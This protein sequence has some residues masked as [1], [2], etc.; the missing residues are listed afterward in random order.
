[1]SVRS[2]KTGASALSPLGESDEG[3][4][5]Y[6]V[7]SERAPGTVL[8]PIRQVLSKP[9][10]SES[11][12]STGSHQ[13]GRTGGTKGGKSRNKK[14]SS[15]GSASDIASQILAS[16]RKTLSQDGSES[17]IGSDRSYDKEDRKRVRSQVMAM[18]EKVLCRKADAAGLS[19][20]S[21]C[22]LDGELN[23]RQL[24]Q[25]LCR[26]SEFVAMQEAEIAKIPLSKKEWVNRFH[27]WNAEPD[28]AD[29]EVGTVRWVY[30][31]EKADS[32]RWETGENEGGSLGA[33]VVKGTL[34]NST[35][36]HWTSVVVEH[37]VQSPGV[38]V[39]RIKKIL[40]GKSGTR[41]RVGV[42]V[43][44]C[45]MDMDYKGQHFTNRA[46]FMDED[47]NVWNGHAFIAFGTLWSERNSVVTLCLD[48]AK[49]V[50]TFRVNKVDSS[51]WEKLL[52][53]GRADEGPVIA[54][55]ENLPDVPL[56]AF[57]QD[58]YA[59]SG[60]ELSKFVSS[61]PDEEGQALLK[62]I[63][64]REEALVDEVCGKEV[65]LEAKR[66]ARLASMAGTSV[67]T[68]SVSGG[69]TSFGRSTVSG[70]V[71]SRTMSGHGSIAYSRAG[72]IGGKSLKSM[73]T[74][75]KVAGSFVRR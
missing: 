22:M 10:G 18:Y 51:H 16:T 43:R 25:Q 62:K 31:E 32:M 73:A 33:E 35:K 56:Y 65:D 26:S 21:A 55:I 52:A 7:N 15:R 2:F 69:S 37:P 11:G 71:M 39:W 23:M 53:S 48:T 66:K 57:A 34:F 6:N 67:G 68:G 41:A 58:L 40:A 29:E 44:D 64:G 46:F 75:V 61:E 3:P 60:F 8:P 24:I 45:E 13:T 4:S 14:P 54:R 72:S 12:R 19:H 74:S 59:G 38:H 70:S 49:R 30:N 50:L 17:F 9:L 1:M 47:G 36:D 28:E 27:P 20:Y 63:T 5:S 42:V